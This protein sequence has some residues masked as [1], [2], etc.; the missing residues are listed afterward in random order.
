MGTREEARYRVQ[1]AFEGWGEGRVQIKGGRGHRA[2]VSD[3]CSSEGLDTRQ[4]AE[5]GG[6]PGPE[7]ELLVPGVQGNLQTTTLAEAQ[8]ILGS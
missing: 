7:T 5:Q 4:G 1:G 8:C 2:N 3:R 6:Y